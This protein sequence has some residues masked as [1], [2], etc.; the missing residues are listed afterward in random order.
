M[1]EAIDIDQLIRAV[2]IYMAAGPGEKEQVSLSLQSALDAYIDRRVELR[3]ERFVEAYVRITSG[4]TQA[5][6]ERAE[7][8][9]RE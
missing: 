5:A 1:A 8:S 2:Q 9:G 6:G 3:L 7:D 4:Q